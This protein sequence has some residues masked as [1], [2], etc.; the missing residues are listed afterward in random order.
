[1]DKKIAI[2]QPYIFPYIGYFQLLNAVDTFVFFN[3]VN[4]IKGGWINRNKILVNKKESLFTI[5]LSNSSSF[6][7]IEDTK[8]DLSKIEAFK[9][10]WLRTISQSY[11]KA[12]YYRQVIPVLKDFLLSNNRQY[13]SELAM[14][15]VMWVS[16][17]LGLNTNFQVSSLH[18]PESRGLDKSQRLI[19]IIN[20]EGAKE[21]IN[22]IGG[23]DL[24]NKEEFNK[25][26]IELQFIKSADL[27]YKQFD[28]D[29]VPSLSI[30]DVMM[31]NSIEEIQEMLNNFELL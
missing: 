29:F 25:S 1:M 17:Y 31:F 30:I 10:K 7:T 21:F 4:Y 5:S 28:I 9:I 26:K 20:K 12:P 11:V 15:S 18:H 22:P 27:K 16:N 14:D 3:D 6:K 8:I 19:T 23:V 2:M 13:I 24:Y